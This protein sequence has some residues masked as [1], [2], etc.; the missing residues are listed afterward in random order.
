MQ[1]HLLISVHACNGTKSVLGC[2]SICYI[3]HMVGVLAGCMQ[4][5]NYADA[6]FLSAFV[7]T[8]SQPLLKN[9]VYTYA[10]HHTCNTYAQHHTCNTYAQHHTCNTYA[11]HHTCNTYA[12]HHTCNTYAQHHTCNTY[13]QHHTCNTIRHSKLCV[14]VVHQHTHFGGHS[15]QSLALERAITASSVRLSVRAAYA[16]LLDF[17][18]VLL[19][20][21]HT[22]HSSRLTVANHILPFAMS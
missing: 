15:R 22:L 2:I 10:Q 16:L 1:P 7:I 17:Y 13:A 21:S 14:V 12:Q 3:A 20:L 18:H 6:I 8:S 5:N 11:Q 9:S 19:S 4:L